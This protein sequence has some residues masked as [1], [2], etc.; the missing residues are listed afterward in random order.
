MIDCLG[1]LIG[2]LAA[3]KGYLSYCW[4]VQ[5]RENESPSLIHISREFNILDEE[6]RR[7]HPRTKVPKICGPLTPI[8]P[9]DLLALH[10][11][12]ALDREPRDARWWHAEDLLRLSLH[13]RRS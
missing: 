9:L 10:P 2:S 13:W 6:L 5:S 1:N 8:T 7:F 11:M 12:T 4:E 3:I